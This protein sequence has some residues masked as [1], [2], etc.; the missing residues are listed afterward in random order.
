[1]NTSEEFHS[2]EV[3]FRIALWANIVAWLAL[4][5]SL[6]VFANTAYSIASN[7]ASISQTL[8]PSAFGKISAFA[9]LF[10][11]PLTGGIFVFLAL[12]GLSQLLYLGLDVYYRNAGEEEI[13]VEPLPEMPQED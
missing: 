10:L 11:D 5:L 9:N 7:W 6:L 1:M 12:R 4:A 8:P 13:E 2:E 3:V